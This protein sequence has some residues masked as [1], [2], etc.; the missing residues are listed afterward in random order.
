MWNPNMQNRKSEKLLGL[1]Q[2]SWGP[3]SIHEVSVI[4]PLGSLEIRVYNR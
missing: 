4:L 2:R 1:K 3:S